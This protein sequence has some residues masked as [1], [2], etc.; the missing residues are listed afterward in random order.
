M[1]E[2][3]NERI[4]QCEQRITE[5]VGARLAAEALYAQEKSCAH[6]TL[7]VLATVAESD[8]RDA[9]FHAKAQQRDPLAASSVLMGLVDK[10]LLK[11]S[12]T[13]ADLSRVL[14][15]LDI[16]AQHIGYQDVR[17]ME[18]FHKKGEDPYAE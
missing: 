5:T 2:R 16:L 4:Q 9:L 15:A 8:A 7:L 1:T 17:D 13:A 12:Y 6:T 18:S 11:E 10:L 14:H 3:Q